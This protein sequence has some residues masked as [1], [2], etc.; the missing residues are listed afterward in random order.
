[1]QHVKIRI[2]KERRSVAK[3][4]MRRIFGPRLNRYPA[5]VGVGRFI[6][7][8]TVTAIDRIFALAL[9]STESIWFIR[10]VLE[11]EYATA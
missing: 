10:N 1:M 8:D 7:D 3:I 4:V 5:N 11:T 9:S 6:N 2:A